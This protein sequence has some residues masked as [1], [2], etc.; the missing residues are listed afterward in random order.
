MI[1]HPAGPAGPVPSASRGP[2]AQGLPAQA[3]PAQVSMLGHVDVA[4]RSFGQPNSARRQFDFLD[5]SYEWRRVFS[6]LFGPSCSS[7]WRRAAAW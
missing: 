4:L 5:D 1:S 7:W 3:P 2:L 6:E